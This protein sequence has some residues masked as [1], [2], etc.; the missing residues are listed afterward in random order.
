[1]RRTFGYGEVVISE[2]D[3]ARAWNEPMRPAAS[4]ATAP[5]IKP[6]ADP[7]FERWAAETTRYDP[8][9]IERE[10]LAARHLAARPTAPPIVPM[11]PPAASVTP[12]GFMSPARRA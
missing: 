11:E 10:E 1:M 7:D 2:D 12:P 5:L 3:A 9:V 6:K 8:W 4:P